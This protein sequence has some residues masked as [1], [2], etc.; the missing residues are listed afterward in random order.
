MKEKYIFLLIF[1]LLNLLNIISSAPT[2]FSLNEAIKGSLAD[3][4]YVYYS[5]K[6]PQL[7][8]VDSKFLLIEARRNEEQDFLDN[9]FSDPNLYIS[10]TE[11]YPGPNK[12]TWSSNRFGDEIISINQNHVKSGST[13]Y[14]SIYC[15]FKCNYILDAKLYNNYEMKEDKLYTVSMI[16]DDV[17]KANFKTRKNFEKIKIHCISGKM[18]PFRI[19][20]A[21]KDPSSSNTIASKP[22]FI[23]GYYFL[24]KKGDENYATEQEY[25]ILI[26]NK[27]FKQD[28][29][30]WIIY[31]D[32]DTEISELSSLFGNASPDSANCYYFTIDKQHQNKNIIISTTLFNG[33]GYIK[34]GGWEKVKEMKVKTEDKNTY[35]IISDKSIL[36]TE[37]NF[38]DY[39]DFIKEQSRDLHFCFIAS[40]ETS[41]MIKVYYQE[42]SEQ[43]QKLNYLLP[44]MASD[45]ML[46][47]NSLTKYRLFYFEQNKDIKVELKVKSG[48]PKLYLFFSDDENN[49]INK[50]KLDQMIKNSTVIKPTEAYYRKFEI[51]IEKSDNKCIL[52]SNKGENNCK[53][54]VVVNCQGSANCLYDLSFDHLG[55]I[56]NMKQKVLYSNVITENEVDKYRISIVD[57]N[58]R[59]FAVILSQNTGNIKLKFSKYISENGEINIE[60]TEKFNK[61]YMPNVIEIKSEDF[62]S[63][64][65]KG[66]FEI[67]VIGYSF[68]SY[69][70]YYY[71]FD[72]DNT[73]L[74]HKTISMHLTKGNIIQDYIKDNHNIKVYSYD[75]SNIGNQK[76]DLF[77]F[78]DPPPYG[79]YNIYVFKNL[80]DYNYEN[81]KVKGFIWETRY[82]NIIHIEKNDPNYIIGNLYIMV[83]LKSY[84]DYYDS[85]VVYRK[86]NLESSFLLAITDETTPLTLIE[87]VEFEQTLTQ[88][89]LYQTFNYNHHNKDEDFI[90]SI[91]IP[92]SKIKIGLKIGEKDYIYEKIIN[93]NYYLRVETKDI[94][95]YCPSSKSCNI[96][97][98]IEAVNTYDLD[99]RVNLLC[100]SSKNSIVY[101]NRNG[102][103]EK[104]KILNNEK[105]YYVIEANPLEGDSVKINA[106]FTYGRGVLYGKKAAKNEIIEQSIFPDENKCE[107]SSNLNNNEEISILNIPY[108]NIKDELPCKILVTVK[109]IFN[110]LGRSQ[111]EY[112]ISVTNIIDDIFPNKNYR[113]F[114]LKGEIKYYRFTIKGKKQRLSISMTNKEVDAYMYLNYGKLNKEMTDF[115]WKSEGSYNE[116]IDISIDDPF[117][118]SRKIKNLDGEYYLAVRSFKDTYFNIFISDLDIKIMTITE[119]FP[120]TCSCEKEGD[121]C[122]FRYENIN[123]PE[124]ADVIEKEMIFYF[125]FTYGGAEIYASLF[126]NGNNGLILKSLPTSYRNDYKSSFSNDYLKIKLNPGKKKYTLDSVLILGTKCK[127]KSLFDFNVRPLLKSGEI[128]AKN[129]G[130]LYLA[131]NQDNVIFISQ[132]EDKPIKLQLYSF[133]NLPISY[134]A[135]AIS[136]S[137]KIHCYINNEQSWDD[138]LITNKIKGYKHISEF[139]VD[140]KDSASYFDSI[141]QENSFRQNLFFEIKAKTACLFSI[142]LHYSEDALALPMSKQTQGRFDN[143]KLYVYIELLKEY[144]EIIFTI[145]K[146]HSDSK[147]S[148]YAKTSIVNSLDFHAMFSYSAPSSN[149]YDIKATTD[150]LSPSLSIKIKNVSKDFYTQGK[151]VVIIFLI[152]PENEMSY[153]DRFN[154]MAYPNVE[155][156][157]LIYPQ[158]YKYIYSSITHK[159][160]DKT[161]FSFKQ[162]EKENDLLIIEISV[163]KGNFFYE[164]TNKDKNKSIFNDND[165][166][167]IDGKGKKLIVSKIQN[168]EEYYLSIYGIVE[169][170]M[171]FSD[172]K[173]NSTDIDF[174]LY[175]YITN[176]KEFSEIGFY[177][178]FFYEIKGPGKVLLKLPNLDDIYFKNT[179]SKIDDLQLSVI[180]TDNPHEFNYMNSICFLSK[181]YEM[182]QSMELYKNYTIN[183]NKN[184]HEIEIDNLD[185]NKNYFINVLITNTKTGQIYAL[186]PLQIKAN[187]K[188]KS[189][190]VVVILLIIGIIILLFV[191]FYFYRKYRIARAIVNYE[192]NDIKNMGS[193]PKSIS[194]LKKIQEVKNKKAKEK[195]NSLTEDSGEI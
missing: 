53:I 161:V 74:D 55:D 193:I 56:I 41:Y 139:S 2:S 181:K 153:N 191:I 103:I 180:I 98:R 163:C 29:L 172:I 176:E 148:V 168:N 51:L 18:K 40:E 135:K 10:T 28:L 61:D 131:M 159:D 101:L 1:I 95:N 9:I 137:A 162:Q 23:N 35:P 96:E 145:E 120:G 125:D 93:N 155:H 140:E 31:D 70:I 60:S 194:E 97:L 116:Y 36:L 129:D 138:D 126:E 106:I 46:P 88:K 133:T 144:E 173:Q 25:E 7:N 171:L 26:E 143:G 5:L 16:P 156:Y 186:D 77:I 48:S 37:T 86:D 63:K 177:S 142:Y 178:A 110:Y 47:G 62:P 108:E 58:I 38:K 39:G 100:K 121:F 107:Y 119:E 174:L 99:L 132:N 22:I 92:Y 19:F 66:T 68:S 8:S 154:M 130:I 81:E 188:A 114:L 136:G 13:F 71:T 34:I 32:E 20:L 184:N 12:N 157:Q 11:T 49:Y 64:T 134:E 165:S 127:A 109:G 166:L 52:E 169:D 113:L 189:K 146:M 128:L 59:N 27:E 104:R 105:Q 44:G 158:P 151:K 124:I 170:E 65:I 24:I 4:T 167:L 42:N 122:Y 195:Y 78:F 45:G 14:I 15:E 75:N 152:E 72:D 190:N 87:G 192:Q 115:Q 67:E 179:K 57:E 69:N 175:Y 141:T 82:S 43:A 54:F 147:Y 102:Q 187:K 89:R 83:F 33:N 90:L 17:I 76:S 150:S 91:N 111:G 80:N 123:S 6:L 185:T 50:D 79:Y 160:M 183:I 118:V 112:S 84:D 164:L 85:N 182:I 117:F 3:K 94:N 149:N 73:R 30:F 21:K